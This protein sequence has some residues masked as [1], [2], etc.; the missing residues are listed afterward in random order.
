MAIS[1]NAN[2]AFLAFLTPPRLFFILIPSLHETHNLVIPIGLLLAV[3][4]NNLTTSA[5]LN[6]EGY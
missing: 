4:E 2:L 3:G 6:C 1:L 5:K